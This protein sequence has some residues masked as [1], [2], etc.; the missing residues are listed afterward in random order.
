MKAQRASDKGC[1]LKV[2]GKCAK[3]DL[4]VQRAPFCDNED[5]IAGTIQQPLAEDSKTN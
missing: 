1:I 4:E 2:L 5:M 3:V